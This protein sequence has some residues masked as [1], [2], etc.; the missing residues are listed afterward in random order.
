LDSRIKYAFFEG[1][2]V[3]M[4]EAKISIMTHGF[5]Y[6]T[7]IFEG[8][9]AYWNSEQKQMY[10][11][12][13]TDH[14]LRMFDSMKIMHLEI[15][16]SVSE[17]KDIIVDLLKR[18]EFNTDVYIRITVY[19]SA[20]KIGVGLQNIPSDICI[21]CV[22][23]DDYYEGKEGLHVCV[24]N[25]RRVEDNAI[26]AR[27][28]I[29]GSY[30]NS[31]LSKADA[32]IAGFDESIVLSESGSVS[33][34]SAMNLFLVKHGK[35]I[36]PSNT[37][38][39]LEGVTRAIVIK[40]AKDDLNVET[41]CREVDRSELYIADEM[42]FTGTGAQVKPILSVDKRP[43]GNGQPGPITKKLM[44]KYY[45]MS[46]GKIAKYKDWLTPVY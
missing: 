2:I 43:V 46:E 15:K 6:A 27:C 42:F 3:P 7:A 24:S 18:Q 1:K 40:M 10:V 37:Q 35:L 28:K 25:W 32:V 9:R 22:P 8:I 30:A 44:E 19:K 5:M 21:F 14:L 34:G 12:R 45:A 36:T 16:Y 23:F 29:V 11:L 39:I 33:E 26:P 38:N 31:A 13:L 17:L 20:Q 4:A 41:Y